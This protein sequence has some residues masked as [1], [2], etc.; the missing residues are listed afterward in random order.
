M[1]NDLQ[2]STWNIFC[3]VCSD[4]PS[5]PVGPLEVSDVTKNSATVAWQPPESDGGTPIKEYIIESRP[6]HKSSWMKAGKVDSQ[7][8][9]F[10]VRGLQEGTDYHF[11]V[12]PVNNEGQGPALETTDVTKPMK[13]IG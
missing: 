13:K 2:F 9:S 11:R 10:T 8:L 12:I 1:V 6:S 5:S 3:F 7:T 4:K